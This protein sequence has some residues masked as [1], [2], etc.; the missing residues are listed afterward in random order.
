LITGISSY[1]GSTV[2]IDLEVIVNLSELYI[3]NMHSTN[4]NPKER[5][6]TSKSPKHIRKHE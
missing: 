3:R 4:S 5:V 2:D 1:D 6:I